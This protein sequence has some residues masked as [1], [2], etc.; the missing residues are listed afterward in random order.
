MAFQVQSGIYPP[1]ANARNTHT[2]MNHDNSRLLYREYETPGQ[3]L[4]SQA[5]YHDMGPVPARGDDASDLAHQQLAVETALAASIEWLN[6]VEENSDA[7]KAI[8]SAKR[9]NLKGHDAHLARELEAGTLTE[10]I[11]SCAAGKWDGD[12]PTGDRGTLCRAV[13]E[14]K[15]N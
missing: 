5:Q 7:K 3:P 11:L 15:M 9:W 10:M 4:L 6:K 13:L 1:V 8:E 2:H 12:E 14:R